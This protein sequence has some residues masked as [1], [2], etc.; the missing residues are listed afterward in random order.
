M[1]RKPRQQ[2][3]QPCEPIDGV[4]WLVNHRTYGP[5]IVTYVNPMYNHARIHF[6]ETGN[7]L[8]FH[9]RDNEITIIHKG[10]DE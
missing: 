8:S 7:T 9:T 1:K 6:H 3:A 2:P 10:D 5:G 4:G